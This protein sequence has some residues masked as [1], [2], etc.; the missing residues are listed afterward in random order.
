VN[1]LSERLR[2]LQSTSV[3]A[4]LDVLVFAR[5]RSEFITSVSKVEAAAP[6]TAELSPAHMPLLERTVFAAA[7]AAHGS[8]LLIGAARVLWRAVAG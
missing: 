2:R 4:D 3:P 6:S 1:E 5:A 7:L 8:Q